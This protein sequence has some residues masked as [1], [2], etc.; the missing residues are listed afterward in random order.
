VSVLTEVIVI[1]PTIPDRSLVERVEAL[2]FGEDQHL[3]LLDTDAAGGHKVFCDGV[4]AACFNYVGPEVVKDRLAE[5]DWGYYWPV[6][7]IDYEHDDRPEV[8][9]PDES[10]RVPSTSEGEGA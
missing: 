4:F 9:R 1:Y 3:R 10:P 2:D 7:F 6:V 8:W 5:I